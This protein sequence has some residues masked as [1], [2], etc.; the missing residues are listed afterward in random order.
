MESIRSL[1]VLSAI[2]TLVV[3]GACEKEEYESIRNQSIYFEYYYINNAWGLQYSHWIIDGE[4]NVRINQKAEPIIWIDEDNIEATI[5]SF[6]SV[7]Y[8]VDLAEL[9]SYIKL[10]PDVAKGNI[11]CVDKNRADFGGFVFNSFYRDRIILLNSMNDLKDCSNLEPAAIEI[12]E[13]LEG[14]NKEI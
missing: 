11:R 9:Q 2:A 8:Q 7:I 14:I 13:W 12:V 5:Q 6:D 1:V 10:I 3:F 4:G